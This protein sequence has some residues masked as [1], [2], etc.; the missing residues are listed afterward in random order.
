MTIGNFYPIG[1]SGHPWGEQE[2]NQWRSRQS[3][4]R[5]YD[6][7]VARMDALSDRFDK[8]AY[9]Q[10]EYGE[11]A[12]TLYALRSRALDPK[13]PTALVTGGVHGYETSGV[14]GA[15]RFID[16]SASA[17]FGR[18]NLLVVPCVSPWAYERVSRWNYDAVDPNRSFRVDGPALECRALMRLVHSV[19]SEYLVHIDL[20][21]TT[22]SDER[23]FR[24]ALSARDGQIFEAG[25]TP[26]G[27]YLVADG[28]NRQLAFQQAIISAVE[29]ET[30]IAA[31]SAE[32]EIIGSPVI[33]H[34]VIEYPLAHLA[35]CA[36]ITSARFKTTTEVYP[37]SARS[38][39]ESCIRAQ[40][41]AVCAAL[42]FALALA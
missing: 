11:D 39:P 4:Q 7:I 21:E 6:D 28:E 18:V 26:D 41:T 37:D 35:L 3:R 22:D 17:Y 19:S 27:F 12:Y 25:E 8:I 34:G 10:L 31:P 2:R 38:T 5:S 15:L 13:L 20:H 30:H 23:E 29:Q 32:G 1:T 33:A 14:M 9:G 16:Q 40:V 36:S 24:P 42:N